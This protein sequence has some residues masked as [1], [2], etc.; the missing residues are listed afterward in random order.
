MFRDY[1]LYDMVQSR[2]KVRLKERLYLKNDGVMVFFFSKEQTKEIFTTA[3]FEVLELK[4][5]TVRCQNR[6]TKQNMD[7]V[8]IN[9][10]FRKPLSGSTCG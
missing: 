5:A 3:G 9:A 8:F 6:K 1:G 2:C 4:Y 10:T 7:R